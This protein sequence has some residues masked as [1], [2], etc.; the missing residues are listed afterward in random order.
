MNLLV[1]TSSYPRFEGDG[2]G[3]FVARWCESLAARGHR[4]RVLCFRGE[5]APPGSP[6]EVGGVRVRFVP[7]APRA[8]ERLFFGAGGPENLE[9]TPALAALMVPAAAAMLAAGLQE[10]RAERADRIVGHW[11]LPGGVLARALGRLTGV[12]SVVV[13]HSGGVHALGRLPRGVARVVAGEMLAGPVTMSSGVLAGRLCDLAARPGALAS[14]VVAPMGYDTPGEGGEGKPPGARHTLRVGF[15][16]RLVPIKGVDRAIEVVGELRS[17]GVDVTL[18]IAGDGPERRGLEARSG[19][20]IAFLGHVSGAKKSAF[21][22]G[23]DVFLLPSRRLNGGR[24][25]GMPVSLLEAAGCGA[26]PVVGEV[27]GVE[28]WLAEP[29]WQM[30]HDDAGLRAALQRAARLKAGDPEGFEALRKASRRCVATL[31]WPEYGLRWER[32]LEEPACLFWD[33]DPGG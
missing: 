11:V 12:P 2:A 29:G 5:G 1:L 3:A 21:L 30:A 22:K 25:E 20:G 27:P 24:H 28:R 18:E 33:G 10:L 15:M 9:K 14:V 8:Q 4:V 31:R 13:G 6:R 7:Y 26:V 16:G 32:W 19:K 23:I 17:A